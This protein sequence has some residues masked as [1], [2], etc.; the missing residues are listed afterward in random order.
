MNQKVNQKGSYM[1][2][3]N[4]LQ[5]IQQTELLLTETK[6]KELGEQ[7]I[8]R[9]D[10]LEKVKS[11]IMLPD[12]ELMTVAQVADFYEVD[13]DTVQRV[14]QRNRAEIKEDGV[15]GLSSKYLIEQ[16]VQLDVVNRTKTYAEV[17]FKDG[18]KLIL[19]NR[20]IKAFSKRA[21]LRIGMLLRDSKVAKEVR[22]QLLNTFEE[23]PA[24][25]K[26]VNINEEL[27]IQ[28]KIGQAFLSGDIMQIAEAV[29][30]GMAYKNRHIAKLESQNDDLKLVNSALTDKTLL[31]EDRSCLNKAV[32]IM[33]GIRDMR[34]GYVWKE[35]YDELLY[36]YHINLKHRSKGKKPYIQFIREDEWGTVVKVFTA[37]CEKRYL[38]TADILRR[39][40]ISKEK[41]EVSQ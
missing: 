15:I 38:N 41:E 12:V 9:V 7:Y 10:V 14:Y 24:E 28:A 20:G 2:M 3:E 27:D 36:G 19:P 30:E 25:A 23:A 5:T 16:N 6:Q 39:A 35:L 40:K 13:V 29:T 21:V 31:W 18:T 22:T 37:M 34:P 11:L 8:D 1:A 17:E 33:A 4:T 26:T 32:R